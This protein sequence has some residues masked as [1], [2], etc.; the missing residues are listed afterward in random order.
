[1]IRSAELFQS[2]L[3]E[4]GVKAV[5]IFPHPFFGPLLRRGFLQKWLG[6]LDKFVI[7]PVL[8]LWKALDCDVVHI[9]DHSNAMYRFWVR[10]RTVIV[11]CNDL[12]AVRSALGEFRENPTGFSGRLLQKWILAGLRRADFL[13]AISDATLY[14]V[15][16]IVQIE[17]DR[18]ARI[19]L[20]LGQAF[21][22]ELRN[23]DQKSGVS[24]SES[25]PRQSGDSY[26]LHIGGDAWYKNRLG[27]IHIYSMLRT[28]MGSSAPRLVMIGPRM[29]VA[30][31]GIE[32][33]Q[34]VS[35]LEI[36]EL[37]RNARL[38]LFPSIAEGFGWPVLEALACGCPVV[39]TGIPP[40]TEAG[41]DAAIYL[42]DPENIESAAETV[43]QALQVGS[44]EREVLREKGFVHARQFSAVKMIEQYLRLYQRTKSRPFGIAIS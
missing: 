4:A 30:L 44:V 23:N 43:Y 24:N 20:P 29:E 6:Y 11:T 15:H 34:N 22:E 36:V 12:L 38:F 37:Y 8:L 27:V 35:D 16:R 26:I 42:S 40:L 31:E 5:T 19:Y 1:M 7:F 41:G 9:V 10:F 3:E 18:C 21:F 25:S 17:K 33:V 39:T 14:D 13:V 32:F 28:K 2:G